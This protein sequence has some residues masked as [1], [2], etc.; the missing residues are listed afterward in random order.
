MSTEIK[1][2]VMMD[3]V[4]KHPKKAMAGGCLFVV[5][6]ALLEFGGPL[7]EALPDD[8]A[9]LVCKSV[10]TVGQ[11]V[12]DQLEVEAEPPVISAPESRP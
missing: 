6:G 10:V 4:K 3:L 2:T 5:L 11:G 7:C 9:K 1:G 12:V 8:V